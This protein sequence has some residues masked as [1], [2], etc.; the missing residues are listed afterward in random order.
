MIRRALEERRIDITESWLV[1]D[2][3]TDIE[4]GVKVGLKSILVLT[5]YGEAHIVAV[6]ESFP[7]T[8]IAA[9]LSAAVELVLRFNRR[10]QR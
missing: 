3:E 5:G 6:R 2:K 10:R 7:E 9:N 1:G 4:L 8:L